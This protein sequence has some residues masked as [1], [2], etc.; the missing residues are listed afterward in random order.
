MVSLTETKK[1]QRGLQHT[2][3]GCTVTTPS[4]DW[5]SHDSH[6]GAFPI[7]QSTSSLISSNPSN[8]QVGQTKA[9]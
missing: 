4:T 6:A 1:K 5:S 7:A 3:F 9:F 2:N 8:I